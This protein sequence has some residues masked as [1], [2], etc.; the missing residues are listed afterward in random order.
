MNKEK[1]YDI[2]IPVGRKDVNF[3]PRVVE[4]IT[5]CLSGVEHI[6]I[7]T[8]QKYISGI[9]KKLR[10]YTQCVVLD[11]NNLLQGL[12]FIKVRELI[13]RNAPQYVDMTG[14]YFQQFLKLGFAISK[15]SKQYY[16][17]WDAD[18]LPL[19]P[20]KFFDGDKILFN[21]KHENH[22]AYFD[23]MTQ[24]LGFGKQVE[25][26]FISESMMFSVAIV[27]EMISMIN[28][29]SDKTY[30]IENIIKSCDLERSPQSFSEF[31][32]YGNY[33]AKYHP[34]LYKPRHLN[35]FREAGL[36]RGRYISEKQLREMSFDLDMASFE[37]SHMPSFPYN[38]P[39]LI[40]FVNKKV[41][42]IKALSI[43]EIIEELS[44]EF[45]GKQHLE[46]GFYRLPDRPMGSN[47]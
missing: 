42:K 12:S 16:L 8:N 23:T 17:S 29:S 2:I 21:P 46:E 14:W 1:T 7:L 13:K 43:K 5:R 34:E 45:S 33:C 20:I 15:Y 47:M 3:V 19:A 25:V 31:E 24:I 11:E 36:I 26:S 30:W 44:S 18:T 22:V 35:T 41:T 9:S 37:L 39:N 10:K 32:T 4:F 28:I 40:W 6:Y 38:I 27:K